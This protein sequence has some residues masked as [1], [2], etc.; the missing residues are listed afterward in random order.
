ME[1]N[2]KNFGQIV[3]QLEVEME[4]SK[5]AQTREGQAYLGHIEQLQQKASDLQAELDKKTKALEEY[6]RELK[7]FR[8]VPGI[9]NFGELSKDGGGS[10]IIDKTEC[11][12]S[13]NP[14]HQANHRRGS[15]R[16]TQMPSKGR[17]LENLGKENGFLFDDGKGGLLPV[18]Y[19]QK[20]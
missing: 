18:F 10:D 16:P 2:A 19:Y 14:D 8:R 17:E 11:T 9:H 12:Y 1:N 3:K 7:Q 4:K 20:R 13:A 5:K 15:R 6:R